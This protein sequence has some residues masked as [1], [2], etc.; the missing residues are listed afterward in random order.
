MSGKNL[1]IIAIIFGLFAAFFIA[2]F[3]NIGI[4]GVNT[5]PVVVAI[6]DISPG[7]PIG[8]NQIKVVNWPSQITQ[9]N[10]LADS[11]FVINRISR[12][13]IYSGQPIIDSMLVLPNSKGG[14]SSMIADGKRAITVRVN[15]VIAVA[16]FVLPGSYVDVL[17]NIKNS[18][19]SIFSKTVLSKVKILAVAQE[20]E[21]NPKKP[22]VVNAVTLELTPKETELLDVARS[23]G[24]LSLSLRNEFDQSSEISMGTNF[25]E[26]LT[27]GKHQ[28]SEKEGTSISNNLNKVEIYK[29]NVKNEN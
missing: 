14:L 9:K 26:L 19:G 10:F 20:T 23:S 11:K 7:S 5:K 16:G 12:Q 2:R 24:N 21:A 25:N 13:T 3:L 18:N 6:Q 28:N 17:V 15:E 22:K 8:T 29:G 4:S 27:I 1:I